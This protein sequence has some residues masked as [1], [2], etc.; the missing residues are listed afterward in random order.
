MLLS[1]DTKYWVVKVKHPSID[2]FEKKMNNLILVLYTSIIFASL[3]GIYILGMADLGSFFYLMYSNK[4]ASI[5]SAISNIYN[6]TL[7][8]LYNNTLRISSIAYSLP[9]KC[10]RCIN[11]LNPLKKLRFYKRSDR[12]SVK[13][14]I[15]LHRKY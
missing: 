5:M 12:K 11:S 2:I 7:C 14:S 6:S 10:I 13:F 8:K 1:V 9:Y 3:F 4:H 15:L